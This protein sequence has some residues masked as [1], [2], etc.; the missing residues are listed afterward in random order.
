MNQPTDAIPSV[1][2][3]LRHEKINLLRLPAPPTVQKSA[4]LR[5]GLQRMKEHRSGTV[6]ICDGDRL[7]GIFTERDVLMKLLDRQVDLD[8]PVTTFMT[9]NPRH[10]GPDDNLKDAIRVMTEGDYRHVPILDPQGKPVGLLGARD[11]VDF[12]AEHFPAEV[13]NLPPRLHQEVA[14]P[15]GA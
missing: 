8:A 7:L 6:L 10:L 9:A 11:L 15:E 13:V 4:R 2:E 14:A 5:E 12:I 3:T 1:E